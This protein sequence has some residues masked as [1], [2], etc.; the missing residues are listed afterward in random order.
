MVYI[1]NW[2]FMMVV[3]VLLFVSYNR[4]SIPRVDIGILNK[5]GEINF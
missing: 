5:L 1:L 4:D 3:I 2:A